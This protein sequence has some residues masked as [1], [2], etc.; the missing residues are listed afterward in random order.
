MRLSFCV[1][2][3]PPPGRK[4]QKIHVTD[5]DPEWELKGHPD[6]YMRDVCVKC[7]DYMRGFDEVTAGLL[8]ALLAFGLSLPLFLV[9]GLG[10]GDVKLLTACG[11]FLGPSRLLSALLITALVGG[12]MALAAI[13]QRGAL[14]QTLR[15]CRDIVVG[16][17]SPARRDGLPTL[18]SPGA[19]TVPYGVAIAIGAVAAWFI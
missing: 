16:I 19:I 15:N 13:I 18:T 3:I 14:L 12:V 11:A 2:S 4:R 1:V 10:A 9:R 8:G 5:Y 7:I 6:S 17:F